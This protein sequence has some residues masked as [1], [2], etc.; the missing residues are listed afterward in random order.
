MS[1][2]SAISPRSGFVQLAKGKAFS[3]QMPAG[4][5]RD[6][7]RNDTLSYTATLSNG[8][9]LPTWLK[10][11][12]A[13]QTFSGAA[14]ANAKDAIDVKI[15]ANDGHGASSTA[16]DVFRVSFGNKTVLPT[17]PKGNEGVGNGPDA[18]PP[19]HTVNQNDGPGTGPGQPG[20]KP[21]S[22]QDDPLARFLDS[23]KADGKAAHPALPTLDRGMFERWLSEPLGT[24][25]P[26]DPDRSRHAGERIE[27]HWAQLLRA[28]DRMDAE[29][30]GL[31]AW[32]RPGQGADLAGLTGLLSGSAA[33][34]RFGQ[35]SIG[36]ATGGTQ[37]KGFA[38]LREGVSKLTC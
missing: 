27:Q 15:V 16:S 38:G 21:R 9:P 12:A 22:A 19:G 24:P 32:Q 26:G 6:P 13:T 20:N 23:F 4:S 37:L 17:A 35:D 11:D 33:M 10:F 14:P 5:F 2:Q 30:Q 1:A 31:P 8:K 25:R 3:W 28:L 7:D 36:L 34:Q 18:P 29:R